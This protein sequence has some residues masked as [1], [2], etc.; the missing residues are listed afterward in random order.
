MDE[1]DAQEWGGSYIFLGVSPVDSGARS[2]REKGKILRRR[3]G[4][5]QRIIFSLKE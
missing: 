4:H 2:S 5:L 3:G 1:G